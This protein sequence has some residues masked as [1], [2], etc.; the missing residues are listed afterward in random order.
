MPEVTMQRCIKTHKVKLCPRDCKKIGFDRH[1]HA[2][3]APGYVKKCFQ[4]ET[5]GAP[6][7]DTGVVDDYDTIE[8]HELAR[9]CDA[10][11]R[12]DLYAR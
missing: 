4:N 11:S 1:Y 7:I 12:P 6:R 10:G 3:D 8:R 2:Q 9:L 5:S